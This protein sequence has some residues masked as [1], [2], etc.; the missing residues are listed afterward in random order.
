MYIAGVKKIITSGYNLC[1]LNSYNRRI[2]F[3][4]KGLIVSLFKSEILLNISSIPIHRNV[5][6]ESFMIQAQRLPGGP[7][8]NTLPSDAGVVVR[9]L[10]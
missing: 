1:L 7:V 9:T 3:F 10:G 8:A 5:V 2:N 6:Y 4:T